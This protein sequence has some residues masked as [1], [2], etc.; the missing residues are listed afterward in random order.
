MIAADVRLGSDV[1]IPQPALVNLY[2][3]EIGAHTRSHADLGKVD[4]ESRLHD[5]MVGS[6]GQMVTDGRVQEMRQVR[7]Q[8]AALVRQLAL[9]AE[10]DQEQRRRPGRPTRAQQGGAWGTR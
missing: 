1:S 4:D 10:G 6:Q 8:I 2:G 7:Q 9:P 5:E 3:C